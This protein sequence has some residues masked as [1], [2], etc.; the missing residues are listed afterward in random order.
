MFLLFGRYKT[1]QFDFEFFILIVLCKSVWLISD[2]CQYSRSDNDCM[3]QYRKEQGRKLFHD[4]NSIEADI[5]G[6]LK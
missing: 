3:D 2:V 4:E 1:C 6:A 5:K